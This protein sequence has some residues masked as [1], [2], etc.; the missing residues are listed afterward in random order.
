[1][2]RQ[3]MCINTADSCVTQHHPV[4]METETA[5]EMSQIDIT[6]TLQ[7]SMD[8]FNMKASEP[9]HNGQT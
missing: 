6:F 3:G 5:S 2:L 4:M 7:D 1:M 9:I 8:T